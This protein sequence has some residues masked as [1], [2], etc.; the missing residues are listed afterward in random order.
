M[1]CH[2]IVAAA[3]TYI[4]LVEV[5]VGLLPA[6]GGC[7]EW[8]TR[9]DQWT[10]GDKDMS[11]FP[12]INRAVETVGMAKTSI[13]AENART[14]GYLRPADSIVMNAD[15]LLSV[16]KNKVLLMASTGWRTPD[17]ELVR[18]AGSG[19]IAEFKVR[20]HMWQQSGFITEHDAF[21]AGKIAHILCGGE[22]P[23]N[24]MVSEQYLLDLEREAFVALLKTKKSRDRITHMLKTGKPLR[25]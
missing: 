1:H 3:E 19:G 7:K 13:S 21:I 2:R 4:G 25:N 24:S 18:V 8:A 16:A 9:A 17:R 23:N 20:M 10:Q 5:G 12:P 6:A 11:L 14:I 22:I 15:W